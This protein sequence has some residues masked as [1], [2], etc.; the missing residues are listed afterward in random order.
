MQIKNFQGG[1]S[2]ARSSGANAV[3]TN[4]ST[5]K[6]DF[7]ESKANPAAKITAAAEEGRIQHRREQCDYKNINVLNLQRHIGDMHQSFLPPRQQTEGKKRKGRKRSFGSK[8]KK[9]ARKS[10]NVESWRRVKR[11]RILELCPI[12]SDFVQSLTLPPLL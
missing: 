4:K 10:D 6:I 8:R 3:S 12:S 9:T 11:E 7:D 2:P 5:G 1:L